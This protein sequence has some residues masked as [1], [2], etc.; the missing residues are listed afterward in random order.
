MNLPL[1]IGPYHIL[2]IAGSF[3]LLLLISLYLIGKQEKG[4]I[5]FL[6][7]LVIVFMPVIG[8]LAYLLKYVT[9]SG[10]TENPP[11]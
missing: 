6:W 4:L 2:G 10:S 8:P 9:N 1:I 5:Y 3:L 11:A 7:L